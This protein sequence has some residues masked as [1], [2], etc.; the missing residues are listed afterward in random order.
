ML[1]PF[2]LLLP[3]LNVF[4]VGLINN[5]ELFTLR[6]CLQL[7]HGLDPQLLLQNLIGDSFYLLLESSWVLIVYNGKT[8]VIDSNNIE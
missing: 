5:F 7:L 4:K 1:N 6:K 3:Y 2:L 8:N